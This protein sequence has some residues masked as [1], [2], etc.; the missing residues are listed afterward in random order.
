MSCP[1]AVRSPVDV[2]AVAQRRVDGVVGRHQV[3][4]LLADGRDALDGRGDVSGPGAAV[5]PHVR[6]DAV[7]GRGR[8]TRPGRPS[9]RGR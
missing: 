7:V 4:V 2:G 5:E 3:D 8:R 1:I 9:H 6:D